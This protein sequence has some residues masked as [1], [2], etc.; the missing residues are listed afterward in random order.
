M[1]EIHKLTEEEYENLVDKHYKSG[2]I[3]GRTEIVFMLRRESGELFIKRI[4]TLAEE[5][6]SLSDRIEIENEKRRKEW[7]DRYKKQ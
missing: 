5:Y 7:N 3:A 4:D 1:S 2:A 6:R